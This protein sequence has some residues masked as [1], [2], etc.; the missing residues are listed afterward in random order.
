MSAG[1]TLSSLSGEFGLAPLIGKSLAIVC[2]AR[3][4]GR[5]GGVVVERLLSISGEDYLTVNIK[6]QEQWIGKASDPA[7][8]H[9]Q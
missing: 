9:L 2:D 6:F 5:H 7:L 8:R 3:L 1:P 4:T